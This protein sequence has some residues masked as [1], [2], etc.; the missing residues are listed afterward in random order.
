[1]KSLQVVAIVS[2]VV[3][4][5]AAIITLSIV[6]TT[7]QSFFNNSNNIHGNNYNN[8]NHPPQ[9]DIPPH[10]TNSNITETYYVTLPTSFLQSINFTLAEIDEGSALSSQVVVVELP[11][12]QPDTLV[13]MVL[14]LLDD[15]AKSFQPVGRSYDG[16][17]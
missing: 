8:N 16:R 2:V 4:I 9:D 10:G 11:K 3:V 15:K 12:S 7:R 5:I 1:M 6:G 14:L 17:D 13:T